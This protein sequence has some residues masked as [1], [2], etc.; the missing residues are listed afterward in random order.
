MEQHTAHSTKQ[1]LNY[2]QKD[3]LNLSSK[4]FF[5]HTKDDY[6]EYYI[7]NKSK[8]FSECSKC[9]QTVIILSN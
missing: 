1:T 6:D 9:L 3:D 8:N 2:T 5:I 7:L 4:I